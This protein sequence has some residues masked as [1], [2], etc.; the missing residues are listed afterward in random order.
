MSDLTAVPVL[1]RSSLMVPV[2]PQV[3]KLELKEIRAQQDLL[4]RFINFLKQ[5]GAVHVL[6][7]CLTVGKG[8]PHAQQVARVCQRRHARACVSSSRGVQ[9]QDPESRAERRRAAASAR[10][11]AAHLPDLLPGPE[12]RQDQL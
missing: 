12:R 9:R 8:S 10:R 5:E 6:Q 1:Q 3:L 7:F 2:G 4:F 11:G